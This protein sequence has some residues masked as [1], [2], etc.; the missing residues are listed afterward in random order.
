MT[1]NFLVE[2]MPAGVDQSEL[3]LL[4]L[5][6]FGTSRGESPSE[7]HFF[8][9]G[10]PPALV[11]EYADGQL[12]M[13]S[14]GPSLRKSDIPELLKKVQSS[15]VAEGPTQVGQ[16]VLFAHLPTIGWFKHGERFQILPVPATAPRPPWGLGD[17]PLLLQFN[18]ASSSDAQIAMRRR[19]RIGRELELLCVALT[20][21]VSGGLSNI[22]RHYWSLV[23]DRETGQTRSE[24]L[25]VGYTY[26]SE[27]GDPV[28]FNSVE[29]IPP[30]SLTSANEYFNRSGI[31]LGQVLDLPDSLDG[32]FSAYFRSP[33][34]RREKFMR[35]AYWFQYAQRVSTISRSGSY[36]ALVSAVEALLPD[37]E[38]EARCNA[39]ARPMGAGPTR[40]FIN[41]VERYA[42]SPDTSTASRRQLYALRSALT[43]GGKLL[44][45]DSVG[46]AGTVM[47][48][49]SLTQWSNERSLW[50]TVRVVLVNWLL[51]HS[52]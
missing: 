6:H 44:H 14:A 45:M 35:A 49:D 2:L 4:L 41:F 31:Q 33:Q 15:L 23:P 39:C 38:V 12:R 40:R 16:I 9:S 37:V 7:F 48:S 22:V 5:N 52:S 20:T 46:W 1:E 32:C 17:H 42:P 51:D 11:L 30:I 21:A 47:S 28:N 13:I 10:E 43:H 50:M 24:F 25:Q 36:T 29:G 19:M 3:E 8:R 27:I 18:F 26:P 34:E